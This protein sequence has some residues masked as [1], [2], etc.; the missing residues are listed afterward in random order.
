MADPA[1]PHIP[2]KPSA[3]KRQ[4]D[5]AKPLVD[6]MS[7]KW[8]P[9]KYRDDYREA[10]MEVIEE[11]VEAGGKEIEEKPKPKPRPST[12]VIDLVSVLQESLSKTKKSHH[13]HKSSAATRHRKAA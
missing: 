6:S 3:R 7:S 10:L 9:K 13:A 4:L 11:K 2:N 1:K 12:K 8:D 5:M